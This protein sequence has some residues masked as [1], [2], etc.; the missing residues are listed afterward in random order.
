MSSFVQRRGEM[1]PID[2]RQ[3]IA[4]R[5]RT[6]TGAMNSEFWSS[7][8]DTAN[9]IYV[10]SYGRN[11]AIN[12][13]DID[14]LVALPE[15]EYK[16][17]DLSRG[18]G[19]SRLLQAVR[20]AILATYPRSAVSADGQVVKIDFTDGMMFE[21]LPAF[22]NVDWWGSWDGT[23]RY[24]DTNMG[25]NW[26]TTNPKAEQDAMAA[27]NRQSNGLLNDTCKHIRYVRDNYFSSYHLSGIV[28]D[29]FVYGAI[30]GWVWR[31]STLLNYLPGRFEQAL[32]NAF[33]GLRI[34]GM[35]L[36]APGS[37]QIVDAADS[38][39]C[40]GKVLKFMIG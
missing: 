8:S 19:Q 1:I 2:Q 32:Y 11:T 24:P 22:K 33:T 31:D 15:Q 27:K 37:N 35:K 12:T 6:V 38:M 4:K 14:I 18:N 23:Y 10:G 28:I 30:D 36:Y 39:E 5:Y 9:S 26:K 3:L 7:S 25:G 17:Y 29:S 34:T 16:R 13:S 40:L 21:I 20:S